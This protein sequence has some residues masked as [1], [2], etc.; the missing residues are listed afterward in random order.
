MITTAF[1]KID[2][3]TAGALAWNA[4]SGVAMFEYDAKF[5]STISVECPAC[6]VVIGAA[7]INALFPPESPCVAAA[8][9]CRLGGGLPSTKIEEHW[10]GGTSCEVT[11]NPKP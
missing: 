11:C 1:V 7:L 2:G 9:E 5:I 6:V 4:E 10:Y 8:K 3:K